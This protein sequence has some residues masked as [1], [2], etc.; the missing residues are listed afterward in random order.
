[1]YLTTLGAGLAYG[2]TGLFT[3]LLPKLV[4]TPA[5][6]V[7]G[8]GFGVIPEGFAMF[9][10]SLSA[11]IVHSRCL[12]ASSRWKFRRR[13]S[14]GSTTLSSYPRRGWLPDE[15]QPQT[16]GAAHRIMFKNN[17]TRAI[18]NVL[19]GRWLISYRKLT[20]LREVTAPSFH[21]SRQSL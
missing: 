21:D 18:S 2:T 10:A 5:V 11:M 4:M 8:Y 1:M 15:K 9:Q 13:L 6:L 12:A 14:R 7:L 17:L 3:I 19:G 16:N 20:R